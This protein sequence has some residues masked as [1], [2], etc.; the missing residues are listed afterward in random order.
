M[1]RMTI[2]GHA[3]SISTDDLASALHGIKPLQSTGVM[4]PDAEGA[5]R[6]LTARCGF[7]LLHTQAA[8]ETDMTA[9]QEKAWAVI[10]PALLRRG[11]VILW[12][13]R[14]V[15]K[16]FL[17]AKIGLQ[18]WRMG[19]YGRYGA[20]RYWTVPDLMRDQRTWYGKNSNEWGS[21]AEPHVVARDCGL[22]IL[23]EANEIKADSAF[24]SDALVQIIDYRYRKS[25]M[26]TV[27]MTNLRVEKLASVLGASV[28]DRVK[29]RGALVECNWPNYRDV[30]RKGGAA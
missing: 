20:C 28:L 19:Y 21:I 30:I 26:P 6:Q 22:L 18:W 13:D 14:G 17:A 23:D 10:G 16:S 24:E 25:V 5:V 27:V 12:G 8:S 11:L 7:P 3:S 29:D 1:S 2:H 15:G 9:D 4:H